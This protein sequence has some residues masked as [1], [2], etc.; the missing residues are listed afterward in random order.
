M[1]KIQNPYKPGAGTE[2]SYLA[3]REKILQEADISLERTKIGNY[4]RAIM[5]YGL[6]GV[7][8]TVLLNRFKQMAEQKNYIC[9]KIE[10]SENDKFQV[11]ITHALR[12]ILLS[13]DNTEKIKE[14]LSRAFG[15]FKSFSINVGEVNFTLD[16]KPIAGQADSGR[17]EDDLKDI[18]LAIGEAAKAYNKYIC[19]LVDEIQYLKEPDM[20][21]L[22][23]SLHQV[24]QSNLPILTFGA[25]LPSV[26]KMTADAKTYSERLFLFQPVENLK[27]PENEKAITEPTKK[28]NVTYNQDAIDKVIEITKGYP[29]FIQELG[30]HIWVVAQKSPITLQDVLDAEPK[31]MEAL[32]M[33]FFKSR[34]DKVTDMEKSFMHAMASMGD[35]DQYAMAD[36]A[37]K[38][39]RK[40]TNDVS[41][42]RD[43]LKRKGLVDM[44]QHG[45]IGFTVPLFA[46]F[47]RRTL[48]DYK[49]KLNK[50]KAKK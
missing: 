9:E 39:G 33:S 20:A 40:S 43:N 7:G 2:P 13:I 16:V 11:S 21:A 30:R 15:V 36:I 8:K 29:Y 37:K 6:R 22:I 35:S 48:G 32:D 49:P 1:D 47:L 3:G 44:L 4:D 17:F 12:K 38:M 28:L 50:P 42:F 10:I 14:K 45:Y 23:A 31:T 25:G 46:D 19:I 27:Y 5:L 34:L 18:F 26:L 24:S 41:I